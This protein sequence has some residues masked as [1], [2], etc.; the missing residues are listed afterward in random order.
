MFQAPSE[1]QSIKRT[2][3]HSD[4]RAI[5]VETTTSKERTYPQQKKQSKINTLIKQDFPMVSML[6]KVLSHDNRKSRPVPMQPV[7]VGMC[8]GSEDSQNKGKIGRTAFSYASMQ[9]FV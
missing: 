9:C 4:A 7:D 2:A 6:C 8:T 3:Y 5:Y 1:Q